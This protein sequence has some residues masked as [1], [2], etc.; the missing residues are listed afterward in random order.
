M[1]YRFLDFETL[2]DDYVEFSGIPRGQV[3]SNIKRSLENSA[4]AWN[5]T[6]DSESYEDIYEFYAESNYVYEVMLSYTYPAW[7]SFR[8]KETFVRILTYIQS[9][10]PH[11]VVEFGG[12]IGQLCLAMSL[13]LERNTTYVDLP[14][15][16]SSFAKW[17]FDKYHAPIQVIYG[18]VDRL[19]LPTGAF[20]LLISDAV[21]E[22]LPLEILPLA[23]SSLTRAVRHGGAAYILF[24]NDDSECYPMH[25][26]AR[27]QFESWMSENGWSAE[28]AYL[29][30]RK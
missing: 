24:D 5:S 6:V 27:F 18:S 29:W 22:H 15:R 21:L 8:K 19:D 11:D 2:V 20:D 3:M 28:T 23:L 25:I 7:V 30:R 16:T 26:G 12:G 1:R 17:R 14:G 9:V 4:A 10:K 13:D